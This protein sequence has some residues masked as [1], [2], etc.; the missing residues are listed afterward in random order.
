MPKVKLTG[1]ATVTFTKTIDVPDDE[2]EEF[3]DACDDDAATI[4][5][6]LDPEEPRGTEI[7][8]WDELYYEVL[9]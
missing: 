8:S 9:G 1:V 7:G 5:C 2:M 6:N 3:I 4:E